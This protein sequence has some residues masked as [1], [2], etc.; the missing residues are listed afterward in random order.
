MYTQPRR[1]R[2]VVIRIDRDF[3]HNRGVRFNGHTAAVGRSAIAADGRDINNALAY[4][5]IFRGALDARAKEINL[6]M[7][8][9]AAE[10]IA[11]LAPADALL[12]DILDKEVHRK[13]AE[14]VAAA[15][16]G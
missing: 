2:P 4:P 3:H 6:A 10:K 1:A 14:A 12:P 16:Q 9:A 8:L 5:A 11:E 15:W 7:K 13:V